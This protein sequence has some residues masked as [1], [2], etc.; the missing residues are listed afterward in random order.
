V[1][2]QFENCIVSLCALDQL[3]KYHCTGNGFYSFI[4][5]N[6]CTFLCTVDWR[7]SMSVKYGT[8]DNQRFHE[9]RNIY[10]I[11]AQITI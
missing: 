4:V 11:Y 8:W 2:W 1:I 10:M 5:K 6:T 3:V 7:P 9:N